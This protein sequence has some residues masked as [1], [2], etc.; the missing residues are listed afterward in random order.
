M[1]RLSELGLFV[2]K[3]VD[4]LILR[5]WINRADHGFKE[6]E[7]VDI[8]IIK[9]IIQG[10]KG[11]TILVVPRRWFIITN[12]P[13]EK[14][15]TAVRK[16]NLDPFS[17]TM[18]F[19][20]E[21]IRDNPE[22]KYVL[23]KLV[24]AKIVFENKGFRKERL[25]LESVE[26]IQVD[27]VEITRDRE[28]IV[29][30]AER[31]KI[32]ITITPEDVDIKREVISS[33]KSDERIEE[34]T[35]YE[36]VNNTTQ[37]AKIF[38]KIREVEENREE[39]SGYI[40]ILRVSDN[41][42]ISYLSDLRV[43]KIEMPPEDV[44]KEIS[45]YYVVTIPRLYLVDTTRKSLYND[46]TEIRRALYVVDV[47]Y[48][49]EKKTIK[50]KGL[51]DIPPALSLTVRRRRHGISQYARKRAGLPYGAVYPIDL[52]ATYTMSKQFEEFSKL[53]L[54]LYA[55]VKRKSLQVREVT[56]LE[57]M[58]DIFFIRTPKRK[59]ANIDPYMKIYNEVKSY[60]EKAT[61]YM[62]FH[63]HKKPYGGKELPLY[64]AFRISGSRITVDNSP[65]VPT[66]SIVLKGGEFE[67]RYREVYN[68][69]NII[70][71]HYARREEKLAIIEKEVEELRSIVY[72]L[73]GNPRDLKFSELKELLKEIALSEEYPKNILLAFIR[74]AINENA[75]EE[76]TKDWEVEVESALD[77]IAGLV[78]TG[79]SEDY[80][81]ERLSR[82]L[83]VLRVAMLYT[84]KER[85]YSPML[86][87]IFTGSP[88]D[89][90]EKILEFVKRLEG[91]ILAL[92]LALREEE[93]KE[94]A[95]ILEISGRIEALKEI[96]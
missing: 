50:L 27:G 35:N 19:K 15:V 11:D 52:L 34:N 18:S 42:I 47:Y 87:V 31:S 58:E 24:E 95:P 44:F 66:T 75:K 20:V 41:C 83:R 45:K 94:V 53:C 82:L 92:R 84:M 4:R 80:T 8:N 59:L 78:R 28:K 57:M 86:G 74:Y 73:K 17:S 33:V 69:D 36:I 43:Y 2:V 91:R 77:L 21:V 51:H 6:G 89:I 68:L 71:F 25:P 3:E 40:T 49:G 48:N 13:F 70:L 9:D 67:K 96:L 54:Q 76:W 65:P 26:T 37:L 56:P 64:K 12:L 10:S 72:R 29:T 14:L 7:V 81:E 30:F 60:A 63:G 16:A 88:E 23:C 39:Y 93:K 90:M 46:L 85:G 79:R 61:L 62:I 55:L 1:V 22:R 38:T 5:E 32:T